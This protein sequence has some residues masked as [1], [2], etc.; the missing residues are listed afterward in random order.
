MIIYVP[1]IQSTGT[2]FVM[3]LINAH[4]DVIY[5]NSWQ[6][7]DETK[8]PSHDSRKRA[9]INVHFGVSNTYWD[10]QVYHRDEE[11]KAQYMNTADHV[12]IPVRDPLR[13]L[14]TCHTRNFDMIDITHIV[15]GFVTL[16]DWYY[17][18]DLPN[19]FIFPVDLPVLWSVVPS[20]GGGG[21]KSRYELIRELFDYLELSYEPYMMYYAQEWPK[22]NTMEHQ[23]V[24][25]RCSNYYYSRNIPLLIK[26][27]DSCY[28]GG[29]WEYLQSKTSILRPFLESVGYT[30]LLWWA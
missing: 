5:M 26:E 21:L 20:H 25:R 10:N 22:R 18:I 7:K 23:E 3:D 12:V 11:I 2:W 4:S 14:L 16:A 30:D 8:M 13:A 17:R 24:S 28:E 15:N 19:I 6:E 9:L 29:G 27:L 1:T